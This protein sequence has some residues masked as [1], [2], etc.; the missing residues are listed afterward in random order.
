MFEWFT[1]MGFVDGLSVCNISLTALFISLMYSAQLDRKTVMFLG[2]LYLGGVFSSYLAVGL[3]LLVLSL[4]LPTIPHLI[5][6][7]GVS[8]MISV[9]MANTL[10][11]LGLRIIPTGA[12]SIL[13][14]KALSFMK[15]ISYG[16]SLIA[17]IFVGLHN[18]PCACTGGIY[19]TFVALI[20]NSSLKLPYLILYN[21]FYIIPMITIL[22]I[23]SSKSVILRVRKWHQQNR[24]KAK[25]VLGLGMILTGLLLL[26]LIYL[27]L[28]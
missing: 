13:S 25:L 16:S 4:T 11:Y 28:T 8:I 7:I 19:P 20:S 1:I 14:G 9:G 22:Y 10:S 27:G 6:R 15:K 5:T 21:I 26:G 24:E 3:G 12:S 17:G 23:A 18:F 2:L